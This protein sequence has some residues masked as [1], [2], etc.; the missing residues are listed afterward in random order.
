MKKG[1]QEFYALFH[2]STIRGMQCNVAQ[3]FQSVTLEKDT[4]EVKI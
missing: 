4:P 1:A 2:D 3:W